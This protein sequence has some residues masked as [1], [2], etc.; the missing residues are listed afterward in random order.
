MSLLVLPSF[1][2]SIDFEKQKVDSRQDSQLEKI[3]PSEDV[4][5]RRIMA[6]SP[7]VVIDH[8]LSQLFTQLAQNNI[9][10]EEF[11]LIAM[12]KVFGD[13]LPHIPW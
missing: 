4:G 2:S 3:P 1:L 9:F 5:R 8:I 7:T 12:L 13:S 6:N 11:T 10:V